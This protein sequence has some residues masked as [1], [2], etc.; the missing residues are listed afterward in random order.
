[1][2]GSVA[3]FDICCYQTITVL[4]NFADSM[5]SSMN[6][7]CTRGVSL[8]LEKEKT[9]R[10]NTW[11][12]AMLES[13]FSINQKAKHKLKA[14]VTYGSV[15]V[16][17]QATILSMKQPTSSGGNYPWHRTSSGGMGPHCRDRGRLIKR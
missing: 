4:T 15:H 14:K 16:A 10:T 8:Y 7:C 13:M 3:I 12:D 9:R 11:S 6:R 1:M 5:A 17:I 2:S